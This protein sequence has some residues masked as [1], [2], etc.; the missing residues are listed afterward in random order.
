MKL[1]FAIV[2]QA[3]VVDRFTNRLSLFN[4]IE[5]VQSP[6]FPILIP[7]CAV[8]I[9]LSRSNNDP[10]EFETTVTLE[11]AGNR[12]GQSTLK[13]NFDHKPYVRLISNFQSLPILGEGE[14]RFTVTVPQADP[15]TATV[16][17]IKLAP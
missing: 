10:N 4:V 12:I 7:E 14:L 16:P 2:A 3:A 17:V 11:V 8:V 6:I 9:V 13:V 1:Q 5:A 15:I